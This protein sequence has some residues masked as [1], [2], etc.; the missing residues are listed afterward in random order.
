MTDLALAAVAFTLGALVVAA[1]PT[2]GLGRLWRRS[3]RGWQRR[4][5]GDAA[6]AK[7]EKK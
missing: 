6:L 2:G 1:L 3:A 4:V 5:E 7:L